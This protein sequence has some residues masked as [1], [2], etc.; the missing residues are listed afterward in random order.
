MH[1]GSCPGCGKRLQECRGIPVTGQ[2]ISLLLPDHFQN[3]RQRVM[4]MSSVLTRM[5]SPHGIAGAGTTRGR[6]LLIQPARN[7]TMI[8]GQFA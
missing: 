8:P 5:I 7:G 3:A 1:A 2:N 4:I 6:T